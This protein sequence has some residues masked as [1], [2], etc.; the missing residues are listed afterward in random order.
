M[1]A[2]GFLETGCQ[3]TAKTPAAKASKTP[4]STVTLSDEAIR[5]AR[6]QVETVSSGSLRRRVRIT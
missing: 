4:S 1:L 3:K 6:I 2:I 5:A